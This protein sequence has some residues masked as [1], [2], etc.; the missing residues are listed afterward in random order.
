MTSNDVVVLSPMERFG[1]FGTEKR[2]H[3][4]NSTDVRKSIAGLNNFLFCDR[5]SVTTE[6]FRNDAI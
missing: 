1:A 6:V 4:I 2:I 5:K 3:L